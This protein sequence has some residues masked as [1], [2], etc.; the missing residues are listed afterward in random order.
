MESKDTYT[1]KEVAEIVGL[2]QGLIE[3]GRKF[4]EFMKDCR[5]PSL[6]QTGYSGLAIAINHFN[7]E[8]PREVRE[9]DPIKTKVRDLASLIPRDMGSPEVRR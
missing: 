3:I 4:K 1:P 5:D 9:Q 8:I 6:L 7:A 2:Y